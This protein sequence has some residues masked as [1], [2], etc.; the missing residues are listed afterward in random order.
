MMTMSAKAHWC[1]VITTAD[2]Q[3]AC[4]M[5][6]MTAARGGAP[7]NTLARR[8]GDTVSTIR[9]ART[10]AGCCVAMIGAWIRLT[11]PEMYSSTILKHTFHL[12][13]TVA[14][15]GVTRLTICAVKTKLAVLAMMTAMWVITAIRTL[16]NPTVLTSMNAPMAMVSMRVSCTVASILP[17]QTQLEAS[18]APAK[19]V[20]LSL[21]SMTGAGTKMSAQKVATIVQQMLIV[22]IQL[23]ALFAPAKLDTREIQ[24]QSAMTL[25]SALIR[26]GIPV[27]VET[28]H[29]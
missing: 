7:V 27:P 14:T 15:G 18:P 16:P 4:G 12:L 2:S 26:N 13:T 20:S 22:G 1:V 11:S 19:L 3:V 23:E 10:L 28:V 29:C 25:M 24:P 9:T 17:A 21:W 8:E 5:P 6:R